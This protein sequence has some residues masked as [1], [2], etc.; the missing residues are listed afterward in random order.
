MFQLLL[1]NQ[2]RLI[3]HHK[4]LHLIILHGAILISIRSNLTHQVPLLLTSASKIICV[5]L[6][7]RFHLTRILL[8]L[9][10]VSILLHIPVIPSVIRINL[11]YLPRTIP[12]TLFP[13]NHLDILPVIQRIFRHPYQVHSEIHILHT[14]LAECM[15]QLDTL[16]ILNNMF[17][18]SRQR[19]HIYLD[20]RS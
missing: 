1:A 7:C 6:R 14:P 11:M 4:E 9:L 10:L 12:V 5:Q 8:I 3:I 17:W 19:N 18:R 15:A 13:V 2:A 20:K 16:I